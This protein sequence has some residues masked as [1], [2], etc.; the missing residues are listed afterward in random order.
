MVLQNKEIKMSG[1]C[2][3]C[4][5]YVSIFHDEKECEENLSRDRE[6]K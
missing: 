1:F 2:N 4:K 5:E 3:I 6:L